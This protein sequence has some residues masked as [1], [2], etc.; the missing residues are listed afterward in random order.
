MW[1]R[2]AKKSSW[3]WWKGCEKQELNWPSLRP[4]RRGDTEVV[5]HSTDGEVAFIRRRGTN[6]LAEMTNLGK[7]KEFSRSKGKSGPNYCELSW[8]TL[9]PLSL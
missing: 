8:F 2:E 4:P 9:E 5:L 7:A 6:G 1:K 3:A